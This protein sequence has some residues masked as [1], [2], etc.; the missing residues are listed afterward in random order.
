MKKTIEF[1]EGKHA[2]Q[3]SAAIAREELTKAEKKAERRKT[4]FVL[5]ESIRMLV[6]T[7]VMITMQSWG[8]IFFPFILFLVVT[9]LL[10]VIEYEADDLE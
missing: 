2:R 7:L 1:N 8:E 10:S 5:V 6:T 3:D 9:L 4:R